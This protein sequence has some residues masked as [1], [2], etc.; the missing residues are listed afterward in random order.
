[1]MAPLPRAV[2]DALGR[3]SALVARGGTGWVVEGSVDNSGPDALAD[4]LYLHWYTRPDLPPATRRDDPPV[5]GRWLLAALRAAQARPREPPSGWTVAWSE[6]RG[7]VSAARVGEAR[8]LA[9]G[10]YLMP[11]RPGVPPA[12][13]E[14]VEPVAPLDRLDVERGLWWAFTSPEPE[15]PIGRI[16]L[17]ARPA[18][19][20]R[21]VH[22]V[23]AALEGTPFQLKCPILAEA[24]ER[25]DAVVV[26]HARAERAG[27]LA[28]LGSR[29]SSLGPLL[30]PAVPPLT[31]R[32]RPG[33]AWADDIDHGRSY[34]ESRC[35]LLAEAIDRAG[36]AWEAMEP[37][38]RLTML[39][40]ALVDAGLDPQRPWQAA[41]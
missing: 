39:V 28:A 20:P 6:P 25:V 3:A 8:V 1:M 36:A 35:R 31:C 32:V 11:L 14:L 21:V 17:D 2:A 34:G 12:P 29:W 27:L 30:D 16:Y 13:G 5:H 9:P 24:V 33:L 38:E 19:A 23:T 10:E 18:T 37:D 26:Y 22:E 15:P 40:E 7:A 41:A 4:A